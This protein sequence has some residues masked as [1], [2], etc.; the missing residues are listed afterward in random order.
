MRASGI[1][2]FD[3]PETTPFWPTLGRA[4]LFVAANAVVLA[5]TSPLASLLPSLSP[6]LVIGAIAGLATVGL[7]VL[8]GRWEGVRLQDVGAAFSGRSIPRFAAG[9]LIGSSIIA[10]HSLVLAVVGKS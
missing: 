8:F 10:L 4:T 5:A 6:V 9:F 3:P 1:T 7:T 2:R